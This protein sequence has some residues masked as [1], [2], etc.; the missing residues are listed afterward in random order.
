MLGNKTRLA[1]MLTNQ[2]QIT[3]DTN[4]NDITGNHFR[5]PCKAR[6]VDVDI[7]A[8]AVQAAGSF[9]INVYAGAN[10]TDGTKV[11]SGTITNATP[12]ADGTLV[13]AQED[14]IYNADQEFAI[15][16]TGNAKTLDGLG[17]VLTFR[18]WEA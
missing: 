12:R 2:G 6:L 17:V 5:L 7:C 13:A 18:E 14:K 15:S 3:G 16:E 11:A 10:L 1:F 4:H 8:Q 9:L